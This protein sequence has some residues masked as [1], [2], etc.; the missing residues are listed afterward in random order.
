MVAPILIGALALR[1][2]T[3]ERFLPFIDY[4][5]E[6]NYYILI[7]HM[8]GY[9][10]AAHIPEERFATRGLTYEAAAWLAL[11]VDDLLRDHD[12]LLPSQHIYALRLEAVFAGTLTAGLLMW[13]AWQLGGWSAALVVGFIWGFAPQIVDINSLAIPDPYAYLFSAAAL[14]TAIYAWRNTAPSW[15]IASEVCGILAIYAKTSTVIAVMPSVVVAVALFFKQPREMMLW[16]AAYAGIAMAGVYYLFGVEDVFGT[17]AGRHR[18]MTTFQEEGV[19]FF[20]NISRN[21]ENARFA[22]YMIGQPALWFGI[23]G[24]AIAY[25]YNYRRGER[26]LPLYLVWMLIGYFVLAMLMASTFT[27]SRLAAG[28]LRHVL[29]GGVGM[30]MVWGALI[31]QMTWALA[32]YLKPRSLSNTLKRV[33]IAL[34]VLLPIFGHAPTFIAENASLIANYRKP[35]P[36][37]QVWAYTDSTLPR[38]GL[39]WLEEGSLLSTLWNRPWGGYEGNKP[40]TWW[41][42]PPADLAAYSAQE[43]AER[44]ITHL[45]FTDQ[46]YRDHMAS[47][48][49]DALLDQTLLVKTI[50]VDSG[51]FLW[52]T[53]ILEGVSAVYVHRVL[54]PQNAADVPFGE[55]IRLIGYDLATDGEQ[56]AVDLRLF[57][58]AERVPAE[59]YSL[60]VHLYPADE[61]T[62]LAQVD[63]PPVSVERPTSTWDDP[64]EVLIS[65]AIRVPLPDDL[66]AGGYRLAVGLY[67]YASGER[68]PTTEREGYH[69]LGVTV[70]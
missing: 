61:M 40:F 58:Q 5:D 12:W 66:P 35:Y 69:A 34:P 4:S 16:A 62:M 67:S 13:G 6:A 33:L 14:A 55:S 36:V 27:V 19:L 39:V 7:Q 50:P 51:V 28:K 54:P 64:D 49:M 52:H 29:P 48:A 18:E 3:F 17:S 20:A 60:F 9:E 46:D 68:L 25:V 1:L 21:L 44:N 23:I 56:N 57:W 70:E 8:M 32:V 31:A 42:E 10:D 38:E 65:E 47:P 26:V 59:D 11:T 45:I 63:L 41:N 2:A 24:G 30:L 37:E 15:L 53:R 22:V 43:L